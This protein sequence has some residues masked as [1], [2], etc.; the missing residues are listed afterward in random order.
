VTILL[1]RRVTTPGETLGTMNDAASHRD[2]KVVDDLVRRSGTSFYWAIRMLPEEKRRAMFAVY[3]FCRE[4][5]D[6]ADEPG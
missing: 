6:I 4:V 5:D 1:D 3:A 2:Q